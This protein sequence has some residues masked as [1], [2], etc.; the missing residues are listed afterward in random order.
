VSDA[1]ELLN[2]S[3]NNVKAALLK[4][5]QLVDDLACML[6]GRLRRVRPDFVAKLYV[7][8]RGFDLEKKEWVS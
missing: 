5:D 1:N 4:P 6:I 7:E 2:N 3:L 8:M